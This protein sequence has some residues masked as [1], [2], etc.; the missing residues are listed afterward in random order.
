[1]TSDDD[2][3]RR[4]DAY[5]LVRNSAS[6]SDALDAINALPAATPADRLAEA[7]RLPEVAAL[8]EAAKGLQLQ[9]A[10]DVD[11]DYEYRV[12]LA[13]GEPWLHFQ[14]ALR[15]LTGEGK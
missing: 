14:D 13:V 2:N 8:I 3:I 1:M 15:A 11:R 9:D 5:D 6:M 12:V 4:G 7:L 10:Y